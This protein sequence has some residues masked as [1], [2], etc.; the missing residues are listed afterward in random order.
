MITLAV[1]QCHVIC[2]LWRQ[3]LGGR[4]VNGGVGVQAQHSILTWRIVIRWCP[5][6]GLPWKGGTPC[7]VWI[8]NFHLKVDKR[9]ITEDT[10]F[11]QTPTTSIT[12]VLVLF[13]NFASSFLNMS[14]W[15]VLICNR[16]YVCSTGQII[17]CWFLTDRLTS[18]LQ[19]KLASTDL[20]KTNTNL[21]PMINTNLSQFTHTH[22][23][24]HIQRHAPLHM[25]AH[26]HTRTHART[27]THTHK[28]IHTHT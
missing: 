11:N 26:M 3:E 21:S 20:E 13:S 4:G 27:H 8:W 2:K 23:H 10:N 5:F 12:T 14:F 9:I 6:H 25:H 16:H 7:H 17:K 18:V 15:Q 1:C 24:K 22:T 28:H 19:I